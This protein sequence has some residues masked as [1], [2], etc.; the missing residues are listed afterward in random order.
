MKEQKASRE[1]L[2]LIAIEL[3]GINNACLKKDVDI[4]LMSKKA[5]IM[6]RKLETLDRESLLELIKSM[7]LIP[8]HRF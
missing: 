8:N 2:N 1:E 7:H 6:I 5:S 4:N 3:N